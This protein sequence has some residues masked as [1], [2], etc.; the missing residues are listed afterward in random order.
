MPLHSVMAFPYTSVATPT[1][2]WSLG[3]QYLFSR[4][5]HKGL[6]MSASGKKNSVIFQK[7]HRNLNAISQFGGKR[8]GWWLNVNYAEV[9]EMRDAVSTKFNSASVTN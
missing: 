4:Q 8:A 3:K 5:E 7:R 9:I 1:L 6:T 2:P